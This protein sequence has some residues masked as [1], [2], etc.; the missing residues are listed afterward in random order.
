MSEKITA[1]IVTKCD[2]FLIYCGSEFQCPARGV[3]SAVRRLRDLDY[4]EGDLHVYAVLA[5][6]VVLGGHESAPDL[7]IRRVPLEDIKR[8]SS[9]S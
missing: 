5:S 6:S 8:H 7:S 3:S 2:L 9:T 1:K 4:L